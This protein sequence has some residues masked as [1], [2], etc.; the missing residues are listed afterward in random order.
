M[1]FGY[2]DMDG[3]RL[4]IMYVYTWAMDWNMIMGLVVS[5]EIVIRER[6]ATYK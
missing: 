6:F 4:G 1:V 5:M 2:P 3:W